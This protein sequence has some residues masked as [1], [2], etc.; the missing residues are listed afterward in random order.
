MGCSVLCSILVY[1]HF[2]KNN[3]YLQYPKVVDYS[4]KCWLT[5]CLSVILRKKNGI[6]GGRPVSPLL[7]KEFQN[8][9]LNS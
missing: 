7:P 6:R 5:Q 4:E 9:H 2:P 3:Q 1:S 8:G